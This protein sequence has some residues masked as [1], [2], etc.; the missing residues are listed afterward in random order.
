MV[1]LTNRE[2]DI[3]RRIANGETRKEIATALMVSAR[4]VDF[5]TANIMDKT[6][7]HSRGKLGVYARTHGVA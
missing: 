1:K 6:E 3:L 2:L 7:I 5:H 4:T